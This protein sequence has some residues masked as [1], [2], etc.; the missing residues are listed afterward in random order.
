[1]EDDEAY[2]RFTAL[3]LAAKTYGS[4]HPPQAIVEAAEQ[5]L[6]FLTGDYEVQG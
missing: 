2:G 1:M 3:D 6:A 5:F 4:D